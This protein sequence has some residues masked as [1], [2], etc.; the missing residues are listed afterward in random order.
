MTESTNTPQ[1]QTF[2]SR[3]LYNE[4]APPAHY[5]GLKERISDNELYASDR[6][7]CIS[8]ERRSELAT[9]DFWERLK[10]C[11]ESLQLASK[12]L[13]P[14]TPERELVIRS[15]HAITRFNI[16]THFLANDLLSEKTSRIYNPFKDMD[17]LEQARESL[18][19]A[20]IG[21]VPKQREAF[22]VAAMYIDEVHLYLQQHLPPRNR[23]ERAPPPLE[24]TYQPGWQNAVISGATSSRQQRALFELFKKNLA[25]LEAGQDT[26]LKF[27]SDHSLPHEQLANLC[28]AL[29][30]MHIIPGEQDLSLTQREQDALSYAPEIITAARECIKN[31]VYYIHEDSRYRPAMEW[32][33]KIE[34]WRDS[35]KEALYR[36]LGREE[37]LYQRPLER[38]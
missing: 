7:L 24:I 18:Q 27:F 35:H 20:A 10:K 3:L 8:P 13:H 15:I 32:L 26:V 36:I 34:N 17:T 31:E 22:S 37:A 1:Q 11:K 30:K 14:T 38:W 23:L 9:P 25:P 29:H 28:K 2:V 6:S 21:A 33:D 4:D 16:V 5:H 12:N 19:Q